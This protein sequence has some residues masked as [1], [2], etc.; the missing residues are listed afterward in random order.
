[1]QIQKSIE[2]KL[3]AAFQP[4]HLTVVNESSKHNVP[5]GSESHFNVTIVC[6]EFDGLMLIKRHRLINAALKEELDGQIH[7][8]A[9]HTLTPAEWAAQEGQVPDS[10]DCKGGGR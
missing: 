10:P 3:Q 2:G 9:L 1:M 4:Q 8:L 5:P 7:A 6:D